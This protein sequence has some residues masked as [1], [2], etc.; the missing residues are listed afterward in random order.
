[1]MTNDKPD[2]HKSD[3]EPSRE[4]VSSLAD[5]QL[6]GPEFARA[7][8]LV[9]DSND[10]RATWHTYHVVG[11][12]LRS[13]ELAACVDDVAFVARLRVR[14]Q[15]EAVGLA[16]PLAPDR[17]DA[18]SIAHAVD[19]KSPE[20]IANYSYSTRATGTNSSKNG[21][22]N[23]SRFRWKL[24]A[25]V[26]SFAAVGAI[27]WSLVGGL[28]GTA[29]APPIAP[30]L[31]QVAVQPQ[32]GPQPQPQ[33]QQPQVMIRDPHLDALLAAHKQFGGTSALQM[34]AGFLRNATFESPAR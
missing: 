11:D 29:G 6:R 25:G 12:A 28:G 19:Q 33:T 21:S 32:A 17:A 26:A 14:L 31:A 22:A 9:T 34:P 27:G 5:G 8:T 2:N 1:M 30:Q 3:L 23:E 7:V 20:I 24:L 16:S 13:G 18:V 4:L 15:S 10:A